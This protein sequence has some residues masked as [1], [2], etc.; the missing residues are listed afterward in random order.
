MILL[1]KRTPS[2]IPLLN[3]NMDPW[4]SACIWTW[5]LDKF[6]G[7]PPPPISCRSMSPKRQRALMLLTSSYERRLQLDVTRLRVSNGR[8]MVGDVVARVVS[9]WG[10]ILPTKI[11]KRN[12]KQIRPPNVQPTPQHTKVL[13]VS[14]Y[15]P[16]LY[17]QRRHLYI[18]IYIDTPPETNIAPLNWWLEDYLSFW[19]AIFSSAMSVLWRVDNI[20]VYIEFFVDLA[21]SMRWF[22]SMPASVHV[23]TC[24][25]GWRLWHFWPR[26]FNDPWKLQ[27]SMDGRKWK[28]MEGSGILEVE[29]LLSQRE[30]WL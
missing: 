22:P 29:V 9:N 26:C 21:H 20:R 23:K 10:E 28:E 14:N 17:N 3:C 16:P 18:Y 13:K 7:F 27:R 24:L 25:P 15:H 11:P 1:A 19:D 5:N 6:G 30:G 8:G 4:Q 12:R 2:W